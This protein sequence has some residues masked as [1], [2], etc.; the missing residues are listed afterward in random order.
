MV[1]ASA[2]FF[3][4]VGVQAVARLDPL[5]RQPVHPGPPPRLAAPPPP[6]PPLRG[7]DGGDASPASARRT[8]RTRSPS[9]PRPRSSLRQA[10]EIFARIFLQNDFCWL[11][12]FVPPAPDAGRPGARGSAGAT[13]DGPAR[14]RGGPLAG[15][16]DH[17]SPT[18]SPPS[19]TSGS[20][21]N[22]IIECLHRHDDPRA[23]RAPPRA[24]PGR[25]ADR[26]RSGSAAAAALVAPMALFPAAQ[27]AAPRSLRPDPPGRRVGVTPAR[28][29]WRG[30]S[31][32]SRSRCSSSTTSSAQP[33]HATGD[34]YPAFVA[35]H[36]SGT[37]WAR[38]RASSRAAG[39]RR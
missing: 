17:A 10:A 37:G 22:H 23:G 9:R 3:L 27:L 8:G 39:P 32:A 36:A 16:G 30:P 5:Q 34:R 15:A 25:P 6:D 35:G 19:A 38:P 1:V 20:N 7:G 13:P 2:L 18:A 33:W 21:K 26:G 4:G 14:G 29:A 12:R 24:G 31:T 11:Y 28:A